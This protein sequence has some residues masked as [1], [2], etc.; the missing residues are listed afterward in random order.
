MVQIPPVL[1]AAL[2]RL[3]PAARLDLLRALI[4][5]EDGRLERIRRLYEREDTRQVAERLIDLESDPLARGLVIE[6][7]RTD[8]TSS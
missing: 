3:T 1:T 5:P 2:A 7:L 8:Q 4:N 6:A